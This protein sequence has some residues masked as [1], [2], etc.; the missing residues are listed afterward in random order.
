M[1]LVDLLVTVVALVFLT[2]TLAVVL[3]LLF[4]FVLTFFA[5]VRLVGAFFA[6]LA[7]FVAPVLA[8]FR[9]AA[10]F[11]A[12]ANLDLDEDVPRVDFFLA[13][14][15]LAAGFPEVFDLF[16]ATVFAALAPCFARGDR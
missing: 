7:T 6:A 5:A 8:R 11:V 10:D 1:A 16:A 13:V 4:G 3:A 9:A 2:L 12:V 15:F 14:D